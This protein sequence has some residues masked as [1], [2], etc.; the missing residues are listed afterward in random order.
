MRTLSGLVGAVAAAAALC[1]A[2]GA[3]PVTFSF[4]GSGMNV[5]PTNP[6]V[7]CFTYDYC[8]PSGSH[9]AGFNYSLGGI[10]L[11]VVAYSGS[12]AVTL[13]QDVNPALS[14]L[15]AITPGET[16]ADDQV[17]AARN[18]SLVFTFNRLVEILMIDFNAGDDVHCAN[19]GAE[20]PCGQFQLYNGATLLGTFNAVDNLLISSLALGPI[21]GQTFRLVAVGPK[22]SGFAVARIKVAEVPVPGAGLLLITGAGALSLAKRRRKPAA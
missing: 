7:V 14:G 3:A 19:Y 21:V 8:T 22:K 15:G 18:E 2:A 9:A 17:Q 12:T 10:G 16:N 1:G 4:Q 6:Y 5:T 20:G 11:N 13:I